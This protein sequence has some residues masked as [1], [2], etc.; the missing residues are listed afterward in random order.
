MIVK[1]RFD[2]LVELAKRAQAAERKS[3][4]A[5]ARRSDHPPGSSRARVTTANANW[6]RAAEYRDICL[7]ALEQEVARLE[8]GRTE[9]AATIAELRSENTALRNA[10]DP[11]LRDRCV[12]C[13]K[14]GPTI[15]CMAVVRDELCDGLCFCGVEDET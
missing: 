2:T 13:R 14:C 9:L 5:A 15:P 3:L 11:E 6:A 10:L 12:C 8:L 1:T 7:L 4:T